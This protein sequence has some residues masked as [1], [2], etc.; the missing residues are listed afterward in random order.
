MP[1]KTATQNPYDAPQVAAADLTAQRSFASLGDVASRQRY[2]VVAL[3]CALAAIGYVMR[4]SFAWVGPE[5]KQ[6]LELNDSQLGR[7]MA[8]F[9]LSYGLFEIPFGY[10]G[11]RFGARLTLLVVMLGFSGMTALTAAARS[12]AGLLVARFAFGSFQAGI[13]PNIAR[14][15]AAWMPVTQRGTAQGWI[16]MCTRIG[17]A[18]SPVMVAALIAFVGDWRVTLLLLTIPG[19][20]WAIIFFWWYRDNPANS[21][22]V[23]AAELEMIRQG[24]DVHAGSHADVPWGKLLRSGNLWALCLAYGCGG[25]GSF[26]N[27]SLLPTYMADHLGVDKK[28]GSLIG[29]IAL[30]IGAVG[31]FGSGWWSDRIVRRMN[32]RKWGRR[33]FGAVGFFV[34]GCLWLVVAVRFGLRDWSAPATTVDIVTLGALVCSLVLFYDLTMPVSWAATADIGERYAGTVS[35]MMNTLGNLGAAI[36]AA[37]AGRLMHERHTALM[38]TMFA[39]AYFAAGLFWLRIDSTQPV[40]GG[41]TEAA[42]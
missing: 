41:G 38:F 14:M 22:R 35:G 26:F 5:L 20:L 19:V 37:A 34:G 29:T 18:A 15:F 4:V 2:F 42:T 8:V 27:I 17:A 12:F 25:I 9:A 40:V 10:S 11:D 28:V 36:G 13:F 39:T 23:N 32:A 6:D 33:L 31:C 30:S 7:L 1:D 3:G 21:T 16:W 24:R